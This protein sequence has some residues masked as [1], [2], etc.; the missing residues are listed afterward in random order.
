[1]VGAGGDSCYCVGLYR[2]VTTAACLESSSE[3][4]SVHN[5]IH[6]TRSIPHPLHS[7]ELN[8]KLQTLYMTEMEQSMRMACKYLVESE[9]GCV[10]MSVRRQGV[11]AIH[12]ILCNNKGQG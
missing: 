8:M 12:C 9:C 1:M 10:G 7:A 3:E 5:T 4:H 6:N 2:A 11:V